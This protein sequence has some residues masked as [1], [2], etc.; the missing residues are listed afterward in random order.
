MRPLSAFGTIAILKPHRRIALIMLMI[1]LHLIPTLLPPFSVPPLV[2]RLVFIVDHFGETTYDRHLAISRVLQLNF[3]VV[4]RRDQ[5][6]KAPQSVSDMEFIHLPN[7]LETKFGYKYDAGVEYQPRPKELRGVA[8]RH[9]WRY[10]FS[11]FGRAMR[12]QESSIPI[13]AQN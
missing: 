4:A 3:A 7:S 10:L 1:F 5:N 12:C 2:L 9:L 8:Q 6:A 11:T 13:S